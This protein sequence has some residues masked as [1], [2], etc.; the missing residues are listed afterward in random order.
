MRL[1]RVRSPLVLRNHTTLRL[2]VALR[3]DGGAGG[4][5]SSLS[6]SLGGG[7]PLAAAAAHVGAAP[8][9]RR[10][11]ELP[12]RAQWA[13]PV[14]CAHLDAALDVWPC[15]VSTDPCSRV[16]NVACASGSP[17]ATAKFRSVFRF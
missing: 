9:T 11:L 5:F 16:R 15:E 14:Y 1:L 8:P 2:G 7:V 3:D 10:E 12:P 17:S 13:A 4:S 6:S